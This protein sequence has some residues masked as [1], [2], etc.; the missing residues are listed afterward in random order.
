MDTP[1]GFR[2]YWPKDAKF[3]NAFKRYLEELFSRY[4]FEPMEE[5]TME[6]LSTL[7][8]KSGDAIKEEIFQIKGE[9]IG[10]RF[11]LTVG[12][13]RALANELNVYKPFKRYSI[14]KVW[15]NEEPQR[16]R[17]REFIQADVD[18]IGVK[19]VTAEVELLTMAKEILSYVG[20][21]YTLLLNNRKFLE[22]FAEKE[23]FADKKQEVFRIMDKFDKIGRDEVL[24]LL[25]GIGIN[26]EPISKLLSLEGKDALLFIKEYSDEAYDELAFILE[27]VPDAVIAP[28]LIRG[29]D[30]YTGPIF[31]FKNKEG[32]TIIGGGRYDT[33]LGLYG[34]E[35]YAVGMGVGFDR[36]LAFIE[37]KEIRNTHIYVVSFKGKWNLAFDVAQR[38]RKE[39][40]AVDLNYSD[41]SLRKQM[42]YASHKGYKFVVFAGEQEIK[43]GNIKIKNMEEG[44]E[45]LLPLDKA[46]SFF[47]DAIN[48]E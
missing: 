47:K 2:D 6:F 9:E 35:D 21:P 20:M 19:E 33:L 42:E 16:G 3:R 11:D 45:L 44:K 22:A 36:I 24:R 8:A 23:G 17:Y 1:T 15:R 27:Y 31:E 7:T 14:D 4:G 39:G 10:L 41:R 46:S 43:E 38:L 40:V 29:F 37:K 12:L 30:Y 26:V 5:S 28:Y 32:L 34:K 13:A 48:N 25:E 18:I